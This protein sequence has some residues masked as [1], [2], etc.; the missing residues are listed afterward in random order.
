MNDE[1]SG[2]SA[3]YAG[4]AAPAATLL[5]TFIAAM[6]SNSWSE[7]TGTNINE[8]RFNPS[9][10]ADVGILESASNYLMTNWTNKFAWHP[11]RKIVSGVGTSNNFFATGGGKYAKQLVF[12]FDENEFDYVLNPVNQDYGY[13]HCY[14]ANCS[15]FANDKTWYKPNSSNGEY[16]IME[17]NAA[18]NSWRWSDFTLSGLSVLRPLWM[19]DCHPEHNALYCIEDFGRLV[20]FDLTTAQRTVIGTFSGIS[21]YPVIARAG[22]YVVFGCG[23]SGTTLYKIDQAGNVTTVNNSLPTT[24]HCA[25]ATK[26]VPHPDGSARIVCMSSADGVVRVLDVETGLFTDIATT[27]PASIDFTYTA[28]T[29]LVGAGAVALWRGGGRSSGATTSKFWIYKV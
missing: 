8:M 27:I 29:G 10:N 4:M 28:A 13:G 24:Y 17:Y 1:Y 20:K 16:R 9:V 22:Q 19:L 18:D 2:E 25:G 23:N 6:P 3:I 15:G 12:S 7:Y 26:F 11:T 14:D 5:E 21:G